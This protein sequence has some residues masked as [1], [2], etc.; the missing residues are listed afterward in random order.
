MTIEEIDLYKMKAE[1]LQ[2][3][4]P[5]SGSPPAGAKNWSEF[6]QM[7][8]DKKAKASGTPGLDPKMAETIDAVL[9][10]DIRLPESDPMQEKVTEKLFEFGSPDSSSPILITSNSILTHRILKLIFDTAKVQAY[11]VPVDTNGYTLDN[12]IAAGV[13]T[14]MAVMKALTDSGI[15]S[16]NPSRHALVSGFARDVKGNLERV[17]RW[18]LEVGPESGFEVPLFLL[19]RR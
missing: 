3:Y 11:V 18:T 2:K 5:E 17:T 1:D 10:I 12:S 14:P 16:K 6:A 15:G 9:S 4:M 7:L 19:A 8:I 13:F